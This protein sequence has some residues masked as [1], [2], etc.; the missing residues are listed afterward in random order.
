MSV[1][2]NVCGRK[3]GEFK[4]S[5][6]YVNGSFLIPSSG[7]R[8]SSWATICKDQGYSGPEQVTRPTCCHWSEDGDTGIRT[9]IWHQRSNLNCTHPVPVSKLHLFASIV[10]AIKSIEPFCQPSPDLTLGVLFPFLGVLMSLQFSRP[11]LPVSVTA[12]GHPVTPDPLP[13]PQHKNMTLTLLLLYSALMISVARK[14][15]GK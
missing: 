1:H 11:G 5:D 12:A 4:Y 2:L 3:S 13:P 14:C 9:P 8:S 15:C 7:C 10:W 6:V